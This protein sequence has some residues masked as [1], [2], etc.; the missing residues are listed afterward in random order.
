MRFE[1]VRIIWFKELKEA[2]RDRRTLFMMVAIPILLYPMMILVMSRL[3]ESQEEAQTARVSKIAIWGEVPQALRD[4]FGKERIE[5]HPWGEIPPAMRSELEIGKYPGPP[6][7][8]PKLEADDKKADD[9]K[10]EQ[11]ERTPVALAARAAILARKVDAVAVPWPGFEAGLEQ[12]SLAKISIYYDSVRAESRKARSRLSDGL[13]LYRIEVLAARERGRGLPNGFTTAVEIQPKDIAPAQ[14]KSGMIVGMLLPYLLVIFSVMGGFYAAVDLTAGEKERGTMQT[15]LC[16]P[17]ESL[18]IIGGKLLAVTSVCVIGTIVNLAS[19]GAT[20]ARVHMI[21]GVDT[22]ISLP[23]LAVVFLILFP[24]TVMISAIFL[25]VGAFARD[26]KEGQSYLTPILMGLVMTLMVTM[27]PGIE[28]NAHLVFVPVIN[29]ALLVR[30]VMLAEWRADQVFLVILSSCV[31]AALAITFATR[32]FERNSLLLGG[33][34]TFASLFDLK[35]KQHGKPDPAF[36]VLLFSIVLVLA[37]YGSVFLE[38]KS[39]AVMLGVTEYGFFLLPTLAFAYWRGF[40]LRETLSLR[41]ISPAAVLG[42]VLVGLSAWTIG[43]GILLRIL[44]PP[45]SLARALQKVVLLGDKPGSLPLIL[46]LVAITPAICEELVFRGV[47]MSGF[48]G[49]G[50]WP[51]ILAAAFLFG[52]AH[53]SIYRLL[54]TFFLGAVL[55]YAVWKSGSI[56][57]GMIGHAINNGLMAVFAFSPA[58]AKS[59]GLGGATM[60]PWTWIAGGTVIFLIGAWLLARLPVKAATPV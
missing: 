41:P 31:Y 42:S 51:A 35:R 46:F 30:A 6:T 9:P 18:E 43:V 24:V 54:P 28:L 12:G 48:R 44:P 40:P 39:M 60:L 20:F 5:V 4:R 22:S 27:A 38:N 49:L 1:M 34:E 32:V 50:A 19:L 14:R 55:G 52:L 23:K 3:Q 56:A 25:A 29:A 13:R 21:P 17:L 16:A 15:L 58:F 7:L 11:D 2:L 33:K 37:F 47:I 10:E 57:A 8:P 36:A 53:S 45:E 26:F 59:L